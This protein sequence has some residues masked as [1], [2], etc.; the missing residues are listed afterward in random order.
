MTPLN[1]AFRDKR[2]LQQA[3]A[4]FEATMEGSGFLGGVAT[5]FQPSGVGHLAGLWEV[6]D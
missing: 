3:G 5:Y 4:C 1:L 2:T 6:R